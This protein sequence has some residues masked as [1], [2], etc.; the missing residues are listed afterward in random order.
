MDICLAC[1]EE[2]ECKEWCNWCNSRYC[3][4]CIA[5]ENQCSRRNGVLVCNDCGEEPL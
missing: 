2:K 4:K 5:T 3:T 1:K